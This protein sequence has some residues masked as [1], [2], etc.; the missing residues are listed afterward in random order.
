MIASVRVKTPAALEKWLSSVSAQGRAKFCIVE[1]EPKLFYETLTLDLGDFQTRQLTVD[2]VVTRCVS[3]N[4]SLRL[5]PIDT[6][7]SRGKDFAYSVNS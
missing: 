1:L 6:L 3:L 2:E 7:F 5:A 4:D